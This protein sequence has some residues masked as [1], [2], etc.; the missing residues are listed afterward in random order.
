MLSGHTFLQKDSS[1]QQTRF[2]LAATL[3]G[4]DFSLVFTCH[5]YSTLK[6]IYIHNQVLFQQ[7]ARFEWIE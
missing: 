4:L 7:K 5:S 1:D 6:M 2:K 3:T